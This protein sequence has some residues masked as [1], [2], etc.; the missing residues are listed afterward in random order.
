MINDLSGV[1]VEEKI[2]EKMSFFAYV[3]VGAGFC[4]LKI[5]DLK[6]F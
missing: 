5:R 1:N 3:Y 2:G 6:F 4:K